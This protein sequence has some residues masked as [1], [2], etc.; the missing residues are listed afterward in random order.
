MNRISLFKGHFSFLI[1]NQ[2][3]FKEEALKL[4]PAYTKF[5]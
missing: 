1:F 3:S 5:V 4:A 2:G